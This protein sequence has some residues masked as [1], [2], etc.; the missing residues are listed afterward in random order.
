MGRIM[1]KATSKL[2]FL[3]NVDSTNTYAKNNFDQ[4][5]DGTL[6]VAETQSAGRGRLG[7][8]WVSPPGVNIYASFVMKNCQNP[9]GAT[10]VLSLGALKMLRALPGAEKLPLWIKWP[11]DLYCGDRKLAGVLCEGVLS[12]HGVIAGIGINLNLSPSELEKISQP[13]ISMSAATG[14]KY[15]LKKTIAALDKS[16]KECYIIYNSCEKDIFSEWKSNNYLVG[17]QVKID[18]GRECFSA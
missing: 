13:A 3:E 17:H 11:N 2:L 15:N 16:I 8:V 18:N 14:M 1:D 9:F 5:E 6:V 7:R 10:Q 4:L 12:R